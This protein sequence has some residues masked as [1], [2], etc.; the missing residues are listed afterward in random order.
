[1]ATI[2]WE[3]DSIVTHMSTELNGLADDSN[4]LSNEIDNTTAQRLFE[5]LELFMSDNST[6]SP[7][8]GGVVEVYLLAS[9]DGTN[10]PDGSD[11]IDP[12]ANTF[13][14]VFN[15]RVSSTNQRMVLRGISLPPLKYKYLLINKTG[16]DFNSTGNTLK[17]VSYGYQSV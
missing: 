2:K 10:Y 14:G 13:V 6:N 9:V 3:P 15:P 17:G 11:S 12:G 4:K 5:D 1:M 7:A 8:A 16:M